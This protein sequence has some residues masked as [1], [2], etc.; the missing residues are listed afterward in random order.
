MSQL[1]SSSDLLFLLSIIVVFERRYLPDLTVIEMEED[2]IA[3]RE[4]ADKCKEM[5]KV[6]NSSLFLH[7]HFSNNLIMYTYV[8]MYVYVNSNFY[9]KG[10]VPKQLDSLKNR[11]VCTLFQVSGTVYLFTYIYSVVVAEIIFISHIN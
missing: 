8:L 7:S 4:E 9:P 5:A 1:V 11:F 3:N 2:N 6:T 10:N